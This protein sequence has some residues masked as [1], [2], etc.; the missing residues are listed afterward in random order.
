MATRVQRKLEFTFDRVTLKLGPLKLGPFKRGNSEGK[1]PR[2]LFF[3]ADDDIIAAQGAT[4]G[5]AVWAKLSPA[6]ALARGVDLVE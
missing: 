3:Y 6:Q 1:T 4:G 2:F 5:I